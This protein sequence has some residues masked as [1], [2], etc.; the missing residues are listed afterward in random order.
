M[1]LMMLMVVMLG[2][3]LL[4]GVSHVD[5]AARGIRRVGQVG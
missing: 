1:P 3:L 5:V 4:S 2:G